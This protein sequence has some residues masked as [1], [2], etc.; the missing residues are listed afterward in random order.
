MFSAVCFK[1]LPRKELLPRTAQGAPARGAQVTLLA[2]GRRQVRVIDP[3]SGYLCQQEPVAHFGLGS[4]TTVESITISWPDG[5][6]HIIKNPDIDR[7]HDIE[8]PKDAQIIPALSFTLDGNCLR[9]AN[10]PEGSYAAP[11]SYEAESEKQ[12]PHA[13]AGMPESSSSTQ[14]M[15]LMKPIVSCMVASAWLWNF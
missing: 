8:K 4:L 10:V 9:R 1:A 13:E 5:A 7:M 3:G 2:G 6:Q 14:L 12:G 15:F 11:V